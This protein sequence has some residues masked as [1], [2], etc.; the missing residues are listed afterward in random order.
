L[1]FGQNDITGD[2]PIV[3]GEGRNNGG[4]LINI[5]EFVRLLTTNDA[6]IPYRNR[7]NH[8]KRQLITFFRKHYAYNN[9][10]ND[11]LWV[12]HRSPGWNAVN[13]GEIV[14][15]YIKAE[16]KH[17]LTKLY[18]MMREY[19]SSDAWNDLLNSELERPELMAVR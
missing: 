14:D 2:I 19:H 12:D 11:L 4:S 8:I 3:I 13:L 1:N 9:L 7:Y 5:R 6:S 16:E 18:Q 15:V 17:L 10:S